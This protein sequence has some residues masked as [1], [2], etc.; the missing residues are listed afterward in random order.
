MDDFVNVYRQKLNLPNANFSLIDH[1]EAM[2]A[3]VFKITQSGYPD[4]ILKICF[5]K[6]DL[7]RE[8]F[9]LNHFASKIPVPRMIQLIEPEDHLPGAIL[10]ECLIGSCFQSQNLDNKLAWK[11]GSILAC[12]HLEQAEGYGDLTDPQHL[13]VDSRIPFRIK[14]EEGLEECKDHLPKNLLETCEQHFDRNI[15]LLTSTDGP[16][17][18]HR[19][20]RPSNIIVLNGNVQGIIDW[21]SGRG[22]FAEED[23]CPLEFGEWSFESEDKNSFLQGYASIRTIPNYQLIMPLLC[24]NRAVAAIGFTIKRKTWKSKN[25]KLYQINRHYLESLT[26]SLH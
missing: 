3:T 7:L 16:C 22:G 17:M 2:V 1:E 23:F 5:R 9:F 6:E 12:I 18:I 4:L 24:L 8:S 10:M 14:F 20:F 21:S 25:A 13:S 19:D 11:I 15:N 26:T